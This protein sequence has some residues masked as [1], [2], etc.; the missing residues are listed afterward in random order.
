MN[1]EVFFKQNLKFIKIS[2]LSFFLSISFLNFL[3]IINNDPI[4]SSKIT[5]VLIFF[6]N[7]FLIKKF[8]NKKNNFSLFFILIF[9]S[10]SFRIFEYFSFLHLLKLNIGLNFSWTLTLTISYILKLILQPVV[11]RRV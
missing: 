1:V 9:M 10:I 11:I 8:F 3:I 7:F 5:L 4:L 2:I 6:V